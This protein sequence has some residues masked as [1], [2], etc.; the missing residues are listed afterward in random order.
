MH[1]LPV[2]FKNADQLPA[3]DLAFF[4]FLLGAPFLFFAVLDIAAT[5]TTIAVWI[6]MQVLLVIKLALNRFKQAL[7]SV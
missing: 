4:A 2:E 5:N 3:Y 7:N 6:F 1:L